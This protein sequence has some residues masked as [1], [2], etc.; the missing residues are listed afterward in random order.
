MDWTPV[1][2]GKN[3]PSKGQEIL[4]VEDLRGTQDGLWRELTNRRHAKDE[5][6]D[7]HLHI[8]TIRLDYEGQM[9]LVR[10]RHGWVNDVGYSE[11]TGDWWIEMR[12][13]ENWLRM[14]NGRADHVTFWAPL[15]PAPTAMRA[16]SYAHDPYPGTSHQVSSESPL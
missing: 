15:P 2:D 5:Y 16:D 10:V 13:T 6:F 12:P 11:E 7:V 8:G 1:R 9:P 3:L 4:F 14:T